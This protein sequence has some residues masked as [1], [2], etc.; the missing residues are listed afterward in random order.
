MENKQPPQEVSGGGQY[1]EP[2]QSNKKV[3]VM[4]VVIAVFLVGVLA[5]SGFMPGTVATYAKD[6]AV[7]L[8]KIAADAKTEKDDIAALTKDLSTAKQT[9]TDASAKANQAATD[10]ANAKRDIAT[11]QSSTSSSNYAS[12]GDMGVLQDT[13]TG[14]KKTVTDLQVQVTADQV[15][16]AA[17][18]TPTI[19]TGTSTGVTADI[20]TN[21][22]ILTTFNT[23]NSTQTTTVS[24]P[25]KVKI[26]NGLSTEIKN[27]QLYF[28]VMGYSTS[29]MF[30]AGTGSLAGTSGG[31]WSI[32]ATTGNSWYFTNTNTI[33]WAGSNLTVAAKTTKTI[34]LIFTYSV[35]PNQ[36]PST[37]QFSPDIAPISNGDYDLP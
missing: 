10:I 9:A 31:G 5:W 30:P 19:T 4:S 35:Q 2:P 14:L 36:T 12:K 15:K 32:Y 22:N 34:T 25:F 7:I 27:L 17:L 37:I 13:I 33:S 16:I 23:V 8:D 3:I 6:Q 20:V 24:I 1:H 18:Q 28:Q 29:G 21:S 11:L 26:T